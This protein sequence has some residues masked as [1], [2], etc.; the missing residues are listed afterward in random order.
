MCTTFAFAIAQCKSGAHSRFPLNATLGK[1][2]MLVRKSSLEISQERS[3][4]KK[5]AKYITTALYVLLVTWLYLDSVSVSE[6]LVRTLV[7]V[8][9]I[10]SGYRG[11]VRYGSIWQWSPDR[12]CLGCGKN[13][14][15]SNDGWGFMSLG[16]KKRKWYQAKVCKTPE[17]CE[18]IGQHEAKYIFTDDTG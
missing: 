14:H 3:N 5:K 6:M 15:Y 1:I 8:A 2:T 4:R 12:C 11:Y 18:I 16:K 9:I 7:S 13:W 17:K 10:Y